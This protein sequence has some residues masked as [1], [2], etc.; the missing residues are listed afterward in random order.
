M[1]DL[2]DK[3]EKLMA[4]AAE[5]DLIAGLAAD[6][7]K[8]EAFRNLAAQHRKMAEDLGKLIAVRSS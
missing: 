5:C 8:R 6:K 1:Q 3:M 7:D 4:D 2:K